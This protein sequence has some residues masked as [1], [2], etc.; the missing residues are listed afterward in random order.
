[1]PGVEHLNGRL[2][3]HF[4]GGPEYQ[5]AWRQRKRH[6]FY[7]EDL[8]TQISGYRNRPF[9]ETR[10]RMGD[11]TIK[12]SRDLIDYNTDS[13]VSKFEPKTDKF[14]L[15]AKSCSGLKGTCGIY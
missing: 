11:G 5:L 7:D 14:Y 9:Q 1:V 3:T 13:T 6:S 2:D 12:S 10:L 15:A 4:V 8:H